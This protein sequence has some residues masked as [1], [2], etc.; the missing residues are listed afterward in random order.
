VDA[1]APVAT[2]SPAPAAAESE[3][4]VEEETYECPE[5]GAAVT[6]DMAT[7]PSCGVGL[8]FDDNAEQE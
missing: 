4:V 1:V 7:C 6:P 5:C 2:P 8:S 3:E